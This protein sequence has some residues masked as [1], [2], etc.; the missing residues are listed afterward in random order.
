M[1]DESLKV[2]SS[3]LRNSSPKNFPYGWHIEYKNLG[4]CPT[5][6]AKCRRSR[7]FRTGIR[8]RSRYG[9]HIAGPLKEL[10]MTGSIIGYHDST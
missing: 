4:T 5:D 2:P 6:W 10:M 1:I 7:K 3:A 8:S 9:A